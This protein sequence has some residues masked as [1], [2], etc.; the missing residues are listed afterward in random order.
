MSAIIK[1]YQKHA[2]GCARLTFL[3]SSTAQQPERM[4]RI[5]RGRRP[6]PRKAKPRRA[7]DQPQLCQTDQPST[8][9]RRRSLSR[10]SMVS[11]RSSLRSRWTS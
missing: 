8:V 9:V 11:I 2:D 5:G 4:R 7:A 3:N 6:A 10:S 1:N